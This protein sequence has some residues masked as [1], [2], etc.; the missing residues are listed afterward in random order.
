MNIYVQ[1]AA[2]FL[3]A[4]FLCAGSAWL[5]GFLSRRRL[6]AGALFNLGEKYGPAAL[7][8]AGLLEGVLPE[9]LSGLAKAITAVVITAAESAEQ[10]WKDGGLPEAQRKAEAMKKVESGLSLLSI[11]LTPG[12][13]S[14]L[15]VAVDLAVKL[16]LPKSHTAQPAA[17]P[18]AQG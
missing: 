7:K 1:A 18:A 15:G 10:L 13:E 8:V 5:G 2:I 4:V 3:G 11:K 6:D 17:Q 9:P 16:F 14:L 12:L